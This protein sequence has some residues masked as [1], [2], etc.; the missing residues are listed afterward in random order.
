MRPRFF[1]CDVVV[2][3]P[4]VA[5]YRK[6]FYIYF[7]VFAI[8]VGYVVD[9]P[10]VFLFYD[11]RIQDVFAHVLFFINQADGVRA[12]SQ[13]YNVL[14]QVGTITNKFCVV[15]FFQVGSH[16]AGFF[17]YV[18]F[19]IGQNYFGSYN[20]FKVCDF[21]FSWEQVSVFFFQVFKVLDG[22]A[23]Q[24]CQVVFY[25]RHFF[26]KRPDVFLG[27]FDIKTGNFPDGFFNQLFYFFKGYR[28]S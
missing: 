9:G 12:V 5:A 24:M 2:L 13:E 18:Q 26:V 11:S 17:A 23:C 22:I 15:V 1:L 10:G 7:P 4:R 14:I 27:F 19:A 6:A 8:P 21:C 20:G 25:L 28:S 3:V 16:K